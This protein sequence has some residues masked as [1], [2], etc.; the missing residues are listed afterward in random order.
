MSDPSPTP[1]PKPK[2]KSPGPLDSR[3][4][5]AL[6]SDSE[7]VHA[8]IAE[9]AQ[10]AAL[11]AALAP[12]CLD[13]DNTIAI[14]PAS[15]TA[16]AGQCAETLA[17]AGRITSERARVSSI[18]DS[19]DDDKAAAIAAIRGMQKRAKSKYEESDPARLDAYFIGGPLGS[20]K[21][22]SLAGAAI[23]GLIR[24]KDEQ[25][26]PLTPQDTLPGIGTAQIAQFKTDLGSYAVVETEQSGAQSDASGSLLEFEA[27]CAQ[28]ARRRRKLQLAIDAE[29]PYNDPANTP[30]RTRLGLPADKGLA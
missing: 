16:L 7:I 17:L 1:E 19:E 30:L 9:L 3:M 29:R 23:Y 15:L 6:Q 2:R 12:F 11:A 27:A 20:R 24:D 4:L 21:D 14:T 10:D 28:I 25:G 26:N 22:I 13:R 18:T 8:T 5:E